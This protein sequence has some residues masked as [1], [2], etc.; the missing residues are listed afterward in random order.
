MWL[1]SRVSVL[2][3]RNLADCE[4][5]LGPGL[6]LFW[7]A[8]GAGKTNLLEATYMA[9]AGRSCRTR[10]DREAIAFGQSLCRAEARVT[11]A[12]ARP[13]TFLASVSRTDGRRHLVDGTAGGCPRAPVCAR[14]SP[15]SCPTASA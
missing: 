3:F 8:N 14:R 9:L 15:S 11:G 12:G 2:G 7:G 13:R 4:V 5:E 1:S 6:N 10:D